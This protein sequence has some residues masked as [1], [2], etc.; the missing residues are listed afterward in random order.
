VEPEEVQLLQ[1]KLCAAAFNLQKLDMTLQVV[2]RLFKFKRYTS[3]HMF[4]TD[5]TAN[6]GLAWRR[7]EIFMRAGVGEGPYI[8]TA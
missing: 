5:W 4:F 8:A 2:P 3:E 7:Y 1:Q 6:A